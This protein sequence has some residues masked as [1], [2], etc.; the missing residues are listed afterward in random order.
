MITDGANGLMTDEEAQKAWGDQPAAEEAPKETQPEEPKSEDPPKEEP[1]KEEPEEKP[2]AEEHK[3]EPAKEEKPEDAAP[4]AMVIEANEDPAPPED[5]GGEPVENPEASYKAE[6]ENKIREA[7]EGKTTS[8]DD[9][10]QDYN[11]L[12]EAANKKPLVNAETIEAYDAKLREE[13]GYGIADVMRWK[14]KDIDSMS[15]REKMQY[16]YRLNN[17]TKPD[18]WV[19]YQMEKFDILN[20]SKEELAEMVEDDKIT[21]QQLRELEV[22]RETILH[23]SSDLLKK[24]K[25]GFDLNVNFETEEAAKERGPQVSPEQ[26]EAARR[27]LSQAFSGLKT[28]TVE[29]DLPMNMGP[30]KLQY[31]LKEDQLNESWKTFDPEWIKSRYYNEKGEANHEMMARDRIRT[32]HFDSIVSSMVKAGVAAAIKK[33]EASR[34]NIQ[35]DKERSTTVPEKNSAPSDMDNQFKQMYGG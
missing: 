11:Q 7:T 22:E 5:K 13:K 27:G 33:Y 20:K 2:K 4:E 17:P 24:H 3:E 8:I 18:S 6:L 19:N 35:R 32:L 31:S 28:E 23:E 29:V 15:E 9:F 26:I 21:Q 30:A 16:H 25:D 12:K 14:N 34:D 10:L 1:P